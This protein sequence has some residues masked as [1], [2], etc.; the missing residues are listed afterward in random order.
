MKLLQ[1]LGNQIAQRREQMK[2]T[3]MDVAT[4]VCL[5]DRT[6]RA[7]EQGKETVAIKNWFK[8]ANTLGLEMNLTTK[9]MSDETRE[10]I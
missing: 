7:I 1:K 3:Q 5:S 4:I 10:S 8:V 2:L 9:K 6:V